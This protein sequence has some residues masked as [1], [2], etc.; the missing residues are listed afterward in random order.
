[1]AACNTGKGG[2]GHPVVKPAALSTAFTGGEIPQNFVFDK[3][4]HTKEVIP[5]QLQ[6]LQVLAGLEGNYSPWLPGGFVQHADTSNQADIAPVLNRFFKG[7]TFD[8]FGHVQTTQFGQMLPLATGKY[9]TG[10]YSPEEGGTIAHA[11]TSNETDKIGGFNEFVKG[12]RLDDAGHVTEILLGQLLPLNYG[13]GLLGSYSPEGGGAINLNLLPVQLGVGLQGSYHPIVG[14]T[15]STNLY[16]LNIGKGLSGFYD[17]T[18]GGNIQTNLLPLGLGAGL[19]GSYTPEDGGTINLILQ[20]LGLGAG[21]TGSYD[22][23]GGGT[24]SLNLQ[25]LTLAPDLSGSYHPLFGG[26]ITTNLSI[27]AVGNTLPPGSS[28]TAATSKSGSNYLF[29]FGIPKGD[30]GDKGDQGI[31]G[32]TGLQ[33]PPG[34]PGTVDITAGPVP[35]I[36]LYGLGLGAGLQGS[37]HPGSGGTISVDLR[38]LTK[39]DGLGF[40]L[41]GSWHPVTGGTIQID[42]SELKDEKVAAAGTDSTP[43][44]LVDKIIV[45]GNGPSPLDL[46]YVGRF[47][48]QIP[49]NTDAKN[50][51][52]KKGTLPAVI[53][54]ITKVWAT[55]VSNTP[56]WYELGLNKSDKTGLVVRGDTPSVSGT[57]TKMYATGADNEPLW[58]D[59]PAGI[60]GSDEK[61]KALNSDTDAGYLTDKIKILDSTSALAPLKYDAT[62]EALYIP[63]VSDSLAG[64][65]PAGNNT[66]FYNAGTFDRV[67]AMDT[68]NGQPQWFS[69]QPPVLNT[70]LLDGT[71]LKGNAASASGTPVRGWTTDAAGNPGWRTLPSGGGSF[72]A[73]QSLTPGSGLQGSYSPTGGGT[74]S[75][76]V[77]PIT[78]GAGLSGS[79]DPINGGTITVSQ[80]ALKFNTATQDGIV[81]RGDSAVVP[82][83]V[84]KVYAVDSTDTPDWRPTPRLLGSVDGLIKIIKDGPDYRIVLDLG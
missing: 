6:P 3:W 53:D 28:V 76:N 14:G 82:S 69:L 52:V 21:I 78:L 39:G 33:G 68:A 7:Q 9:L 30:K 8:T 84:F 62:A 67:L 4:G 13:P 1:M 73:L 40:G 64:L 25:P 49:L 24:I 75:L 54:D 77:K 57:I 56:D 26:T 17:P 36:T 10:Y 58:Y 51:V 66:T 29:T 15:I 35:V 63:E 32:D 23:I 48:A 65:V 47:V 45:E 42:P 61:V 19:G 43:G 31:K 2:G 79:Y 50:G 74:L 59:V 20:P 37:Y 46:N 18:T 16:P 38:T 80:G 12:E 5:L 60:S 81:K 27:S 22:P 72:P 70:K 34:A 55:N 11:D 41:K 71:V 83:Q 44:Y